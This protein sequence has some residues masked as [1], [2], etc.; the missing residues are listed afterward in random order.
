MGNAIIG[1][2]MTSVLPY[3]LNE[4]SAGG[5]GW[6]IKTGECEREC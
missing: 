3:M 5:Q 1:L 2:I 4:P 6:N